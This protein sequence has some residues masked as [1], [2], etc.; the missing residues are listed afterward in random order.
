MNI[1][2][3]IV[4]QG[5]A[6]T[7][8][9]YKLKQAGK[10]VVVI[11][12]NNPT[13][14]SKVASGV[15]NPVTGRR[16]VSTWMIDE[17]LPY[18]WDI[19]HELG[20]WLGAELVSQKN[21]LAFHA[22]EQMKKAFLNKMDENEAYVT[23]V[24]DEE[25]YKKWF[26]FYY[27]IGVIDPVYLIDIQTL[28]SRWRE[29]LAKENSLLEETFLW[30][31]LQIEHGVVKY[32]DIAAAKIIMCDGTAGYHDPYFK[33][34]PYGV[35]KG[36]ALIVDIP[37]LPQT[38]IYKQ[39]YNIVPWKDG[40]FWIGSTF[41]REYDD[42]LPSQAFRSSVEEQL[43]KWLKLPYT[44]VD[45]I[46]SE[47]AGTFERRP[48]IGVHPQHPEVGIFNGMGTKGCSLAP[49]FAD[50]FTQY[51]VNGKKMNELVDVQRFTKVLT[52]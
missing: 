35:T 18:A 43:K 10:Q 45:H 30:S 40:L 16:V 7:M 37:D 50:E 12:N 38:N 48:F 17:L 6:G 4:G 1:D 41:A 9:S 27:G 46:A 31:E 52:R 51:L 11:D 24:N 28:L 26:E 21:I 13:S 44:V 14:A 42:A 19:Y 34:L 29:Q 20:E 47:R 33:K 32:K 25:P 49:F 22:T 36:E 5:I 15:I 8:L 2:Y 39:G 3:L 23:T